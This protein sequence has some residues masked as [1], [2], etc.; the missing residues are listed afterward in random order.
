M[1]EIHDIYN[2]PNHCQRLPLTRPNQQVLNRHNHSNCINKN[3]IIY[4]K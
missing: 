4:A 1:Y 3:K 2:E